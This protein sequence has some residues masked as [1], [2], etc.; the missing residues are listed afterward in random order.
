MI[1][2]SRDLE[3]SP[4]LFRVIKI[5]LGLTSFPLAIRNA[6]TK[7]VVDELK[8]DLGVCRKDSKGDGHHIDELLGPA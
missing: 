8:G 2:S 4:M 3:C 7:R 5:L 6:D 1:D